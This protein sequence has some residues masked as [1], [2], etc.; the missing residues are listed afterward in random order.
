MKKYALAV[1]VLLSIALVAAQDLGMQQLRAE[2]GKPI[3][4]KIGALGKGMAI[5]TSDPLDFKI[6]KI[7]LVQVQ[8][9]FSGQILTK[10]TGLLWLDDEKY[11][12]RNASIQKS[13]VSADVYLND[14]LV[15]SV[16]L[17]LVQKND[18]SIWVGKASI[19]GKEYNL[20]I[21]EGN[22]GFEKQEIKM[23]VRDFCDENDGNC[24]QIAKGIGNRFCEKVN[25]PSCREKI[26]EFCQ[27]NP[28]DAR[29]VAVM[30]NYCANNT[31]DTRCR[32][33]LRDV[34]KQ[35]PGDTRCLNF[36][37]DNPEACKIQIKQEVKE[38]LKE[39]L[40]EMKENRGKMNG[41]R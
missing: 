13:A 35:N 16:N 24:T 10:E 33:M 5:S 31:D 38:R 4:T 32:L 37:Q 22:R 40:Q 39:K 29:C 36:C 23:K 11:Q 14:S 26:A 20:Y 3:I 2:L 34:C 41:K 25:D 19:N 15:G 18:T 7:G 27:E 28:S 8:V 12:L 9:N 6:A 17:A 30:K 1:L 21:L